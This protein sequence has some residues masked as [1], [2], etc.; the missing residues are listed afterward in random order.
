MKIFVLLLI[1][2]TFPVIAGYA[3]SQAGEIV[4]CPNNISFASAIQKAD[5]FKARGTVVSAKSSE[6]LIGVSIKEKG[7]S[8][9]TITDDY[10]VF[11]IQV[12]SPKAILEIIYPGYEKQE[13]ALN[14]IDQLTI[15][16][17]EHVSQP[18]EVVTVA[19]GTQKRTEIVGSVYFC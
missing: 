4:F 7:V 11:T 18:D 9:T 15:S 19:F 16:L 6:K 5:S 12:S 14:N 2:S 3:Y 1:V 10:G 17:V 8:N 13:I